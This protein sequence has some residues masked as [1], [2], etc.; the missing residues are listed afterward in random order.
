MCQLPQPPPPVFWKLQS[1]N[2]SA[3][4]ASSRQS[5]GNY[6][7]TMRQLPQP[8][9]TRLLET[10]VTQCVRSHRQLT[11]VFWKLQSRNVSAPTASSH[12]SSG[13]YSHT[14]CQLPQPAHASLLETTATQCVSSHSQL[15]PVFW[16]LQSH[17]VSAPTASPRPFSGNYSHTMCQLTQPAHT[18]LLETTVTQCVSSH[19]SSGNYSHTMCQLTQPGSSHQ[20]SGNYSHTMCQLPQPAHASLLETTLTQCVSSHSQFTP[21]FWKLH[22]HNVSAPTSLLETTVTQCV[23]S[24]SQLTPVFRKLQSHNVSAPT[25]LLETTVTQCVNSHSQLTPVFRKLQSHNVSAPTSLLETTVTQCVNSHSQLTPVFWKLQ[26]YNVSAPTVSSHQS[27][28]NYSH[29]M[30]QLPQPAQA[31]LLETTVTQCVSSH[32]QLT[33]V[34]WKTTVTQCVSSHSQLT[35]V[36]WKLQSHNVSA[37]TASS[38]QSSGNYSHTMCQLPQ[39]AHTSLLETTVTQCVSS[40]SQLTPVFWKLVTQCVSSHS[41]LTPVFWKLQSHNVSVPTA[42][43]H[44]SS[45]NYSYPMCQLPQPAH[46]SLLE[47]TVTQYVSSHSQ[48]TP[49]FWKLQSHNVSAPTASSHQSSGNYSHTMCQLPQPAHISLLE[50]TVTQCVSSH[51]QLTPVFWK[52]QSLNVSAPTASS[53]Q[54]SGNYSHTMCQLPQPAHISLLETTVTQCVSDIAPQPAHTSLLETTVTQCVSS[55]SQLTTVFWK[56]QSH[57]VSAPTAS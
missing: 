21:V 46:A 23:S 9:H 11:P 14:M 51:S 10:T 16:K 27:S 47:T 4:T 2:A 17:N 22:S 39:P 19:Q 48:L 35:P 7:H 30:C 13:N 20:S 49:V 37:P 57:N 41:Q 8:A 12:Q 40:H 15:T 28:G 52:L 1:H 3:P 44:Q 6:S 50:T 33:S 24:H 53:H 55:H 38:H 54:S 32:S 42:S 29:T 36:F 34:F 26:S 45:G 43:S 31:S 56:L 5:S 18:S 25:S